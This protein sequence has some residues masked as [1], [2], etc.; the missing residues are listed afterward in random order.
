MVQ[1]H[2][3][4]IIEGRIPSTYKTLTHGTSIEALKATAMGRAIHKYS[5]YEV[6]HLPVVWQGV[7]T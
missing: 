5:D 1:E 3:K 2:F 7:T 6:C 4:G